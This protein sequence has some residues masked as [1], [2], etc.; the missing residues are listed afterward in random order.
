MDPVRFRTAAN[1]FAVLST[2]G[3]VLASMG[4]AITPHADG[5]GA[6]AETGSA[7]MRFLIGGFARRMIVDYRVTQGDLPHTTQTLIVPAMT[8]AA[9]GIIG[10]ARAQTE[11]ENIR[12]A[13]GGALYHAGL[14]AEGGA[15]IPH[16][17]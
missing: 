12:Q 7:G 1:G 2:V 11:I 13:V 10:I 9:G 8:G 14:L 16:G 15:H 4:Y 17:P 3:N 6:R 5:W